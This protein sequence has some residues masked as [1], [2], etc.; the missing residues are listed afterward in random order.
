M[1][2]IGRA[3]GKPHRISWTG[4]AQ[5]LAARLEC[6]RSPHCAPSR[7]A[8]FAVNRIRL[9]IS[10]PVKPAL[11]LGGLFADQ[12]VVRGTQTLGALAGDTGS[13][14]AGLTVEV[15]GHQTVNR[16]MTCALHGRVAIRLA[17][18]PSGVPLTLPENTRSTPFRQGTNRIQ[19]CA[20]DYAAR[21]DAN[22]NCVSRKVR[23]DNRCPLSGVPGGTSLTAGVRGV[24]RGITASRHDHPRVSGRVLDSAGEPVVGAKVCVAA[25][26]LPHHA[27][28]SILATPVT[29]ADGHYS[30]AIPAGP[31]RRLRVA[32]WANDQ[33]ALQR[34]ERIRFRARPRLR[35]RPRGTLRNGQRVRFV[36]HLPGPDAGRRLVRIEALSHHHW[37]PVTGGRTGS[38][39][40]YHGTYRFHGTT[41]TRRYRFRALV[42]HQTGYP[43]AAGASSVKR[44]RVRG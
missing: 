32:Y 42:P 12:S 19:V 37:V 35:L 1:Q 13:G 40:V 30:V 26:R 39:G 7:E 4:R 21:H 2:T 33:R 38:R 17:P 14:V 44:K 8:R 20:R 5:N 15:N 34:F 22:V 27:A 24:R 6:R 29:D 3:A 23:V 18:C 16:Q 31:G 11:G 28:E 36:V 9:R 41:G 43:Y 25:Q 10:D